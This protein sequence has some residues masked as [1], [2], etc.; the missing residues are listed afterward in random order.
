[1]KHPRLAVKGFLALK[2]WELLTDQEDVPVSDDDSSMCKDG[3]AGNNTPR[4][5]SPWTIDRP[6]MP[7]IMVGKGQEDSCV[8]GE[9]RGSAM[10][11]LVMTAAACAMQGLQVTMLFAQ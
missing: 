2:I 10:W 9:A 3:R 11:Q 4:G 6:T 8:N 5:M 7:D 1:M